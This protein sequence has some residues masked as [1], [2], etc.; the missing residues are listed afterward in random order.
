[1][2]FG[3]GTDLCEV[4]RIAQVQERSQG[5]LAQKILNPAELA[6]FEARYRSH[7]E[8]GLRYLALR[9]CAKEALGKAMGTGFRWPLTWQNCAVQNLESGQP[10]WQ[11]SGALEVWMATRQLKAHLTLSDTAHHTQ[12][13]VVLEQ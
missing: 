11:F 2:V 4:A 5:R 8:R 13:F 6:T 9:F 12:A 1:M 10:T 3:I 7:P